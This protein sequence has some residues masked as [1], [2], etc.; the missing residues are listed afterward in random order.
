VKRSLRR[1]FEAIEALFDRFFP[2]GSNPLHALGALGFFM[3]W[4]V[5]VSGA[6]VFVFFDTGTTEAYASVEQ[7]TR[8]QWY[9]GGV[10]RSLHRYASDA[11]VLFAGIHLLREYA[12]DRYR[13]PRWFTW[14]TGVPLIWLIAAAGI[15]GYWMVWDKLAQYVAIATTELLDAVPIFGEPLARNFL[16]ASQLSDRFFTLLTFLH[17]AVPL[18]LL[19]L[20]WVHLQRVAHARINPSRPLLMWAFALLFAVSALV[21][22]VSQGPANLTQI[23]SPVGLDWYYLWPYPL[24]PVLGAS[25]VWWL[26][27]GLTL[28]LCVLPWL[29]PLR[30]G[31]AARVDLANCNGCTRCVADCP[32][33]A[34]TMA[35]RSDGKPFSTEATVDGA[36]CLRCGLCMASCPTATP[37]R[38]LLDAVPGIEVPEWSMVALKRNV[39]A[40]AVGLMG[41]GRVMAFV[42]A[43]RAVAESSPQLG[44][45][46]AACVGMIPPSV[47]DYCLSRDLADG[48][49]L[50]GCGGGQCDYRCGA[51]WA[52]QRLMGARDPNL[53]RR[54]ERARVLMARVPGRGWRSVNAALDS[55]RSRLPACGVTGDLGR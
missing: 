53:R 30:Q 32:Y 25:G 8:D 42:C 26:A 15:T 33:G 52:E 51:D 27:V 1:V 55:F 12:F 38:R 16:S 21:P 6:Y 44:I 48:V 3:L 50:I 34:I 13:G 47:I 22:A 31:A 36:A 28:A 37:F 23:P 40:A 11:L 20:L 2:N 9:L 43:S 19:F 24:V 14:F 35:P 46:R 41:E 7:F 18:V 45:V 29:P 54:V 10:M 49:A 39:D 5:C 17:I 4:V